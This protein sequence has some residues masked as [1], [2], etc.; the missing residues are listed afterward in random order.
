MKEEFALRTV[1]N[2]KVR[3]LNRE[4]LLENLDHLLSW[5]MLTQAELESAAGVYI[6]YISR[7]KSD[8]RKLPA[9]DVIWKMAQ[10]LGVSLEW[11]IEGTARDLD[12]NVLYLRRFLRKLFDRT[13]AG[14]LV[15][16]SWPYGQLNRILSGRETCANLPCVAPKPEGGFRPVSLAFPEMESGFADAAFTTWLDEKSVLCIVKMQFSEPV[17][18]DDPAS[19][20]SNEWIELQTL[21]V[22]SGERNMAAC[23]SRGGDSLMEADLEKLYRQ[24]MEHIN[25]VTLAPA[26]RGLIDSFMSLDDDS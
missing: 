20:G 24:L 14:K 22:E 26:L 21:D 15:W 5:E 2:G 10:V 13:V 7:M 9:L 3:E 17:D 16:K 12:E 6:G 1:A 23:S 19:W 11:I 4:R 18:P 25:D 8:P